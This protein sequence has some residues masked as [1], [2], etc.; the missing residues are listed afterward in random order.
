MFADCSALISI[1]N[2]NTEL[3][4]SMNNM[5]NSCVWLTNINIKRIKMSCYLTTMA[6]LSQSSLLYIINNEAATGA[7]TLKLHKY[8]YER[9]ANDSD[10]VAALANH[11]NISL[12]SA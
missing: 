10:I 9:L 12:A 11:P 1:P 3:A 2:L 8:A 5:F 7:I 6:F 4:K